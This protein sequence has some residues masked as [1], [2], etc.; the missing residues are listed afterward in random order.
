[1]VIRYL[2]KNQNNDCFV[3]CSNTQWGPECKKTCGKCKNND[4]CNVSDGA[5][6][7]SCEPGWIPP[8]CIQE[9]YNNTY[10]EDCNSTCGHCKHDLS[11]NKQNG[12]C[13]EGCYPG[14]KE[15]ICSQECYN[16][17]YGEDCNYTCG[18]C[19]HDLS[20]NK[21]N[22]VCP[23][24][25]YPGY[26]EPI[27]S[28]AKEPGDERS[29]TGVIVGAVIGVPII[30]IILLASFI[31]KCKSKRNASMSDERTSP[32]LKNQSK[33]VNHAIVISKKKNGEATYAVVNQHDE[34]G[35]KKTEPCKKSSDKEVK[36]EIVMS[37]MKN[38]EA[39]NAAV[40]QHG[41]VGGK[42]KVQSSNWL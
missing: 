19:K 29:P 4:Y 3:E 14:Y 17:T 13:P 8:L 26:K 10:G 33:E 16:N 7:N 21:Q 12:V 27:C 36:D 23:E 30:L 6:P 25:C 35:G 9:C 22:G 39:T 15:P 38:G 34:V 20:C 41:E 28:Q 5:C 24:G 40:N 2:I 37:K 31:Y 18:H 32:M 42:K 11:C 1:Y